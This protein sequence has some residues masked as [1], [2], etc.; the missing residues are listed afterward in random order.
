MCRGVSAISFAPH[1]SCICTAGAD[2]MVCEL[3]SMSG[4]LSNKF[5]AS[6][7]SISSISMSSGLN[8]YMISISNAD[9]SFAS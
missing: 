2:G 3:D 1:G 5:R 9:I 7:K 6:T 4:N 8:A